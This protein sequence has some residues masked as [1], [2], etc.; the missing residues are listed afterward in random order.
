[1]EKEITILDLMNNEFCYD[2]N[3]KIIKNI[4]E[5]EKIRNIIIDTKIFKLKEVPL[6]LKE[7]SNLIEIKII[8]NELENINNLNDKIFDTVEY[9]DFSNNKI[10]EIPKFISNFKLL[11]SLNFSFNF[12]K[13]LSYLEELINL[14]N[15]NMKNN[16]LINMR[17]ISTLLKLKSLYLNNN[18]IKLI[19]DIDIL[20]KHKSYD[21]KY[22]QIDS[23]HLK[24]SKLNSEFLKGTVFNKTVIHIS[25]DVYQKLKILNENYLKKLKI[26][27]KK[28][29]N[30]LNNIYSKKIE[31]NYQEENIIYF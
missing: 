17:G 3:G 9:L 23:E 28:K 5:K 16:L 30:K 7:F 22:F 4:K 31:P 24:Y 18:K 10:Q 14:E 6:C 1:M 20:K 12:I 2:K 26:I 21:L 25:I 19:E 29:F 8:N 13:N 11:K 15:L 27:Q